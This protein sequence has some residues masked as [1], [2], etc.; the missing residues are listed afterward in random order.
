MDGAKT[1]HILS[2]THKTWTETVVHTTGSV[3]SENNLFLS[4]Y[5]F[6]LQLKKIKVLFLGISAQLGSSASFRKRWGLSIA[7]MCSFHYQEGKTTHQFIGSSFLLPWSQ[8]WA[9]QT[10]SPHPLPIL[11]EGQHCRNSHSPKLVFQGGKLKIWEPGP[12]KKAE[13]P[14]CESVLQKNSTW[15]E[16]TDIVSPSLPLSLR[17]MFF[18]AFLI[19]KE[20]MAKALFNEICPFN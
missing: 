9:E 19:G 18:S 15:F 14:S 4:V 16:T 13:L 17:N 12:R 7:S 2:Q 8:E 3:I 6:D 5:H 1:K 10:D 20:Q 11:C